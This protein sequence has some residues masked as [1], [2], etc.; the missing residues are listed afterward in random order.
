MRW[1]ALITATLCTS[2]AAAS[3]AAASDHPWAGFRDPCR[4]LDTNV[5]FG[6]EVNSY[7]CRGSHTCRVIAI[8]VYEQGG[9]FMPIYGCKRLVRATRTRR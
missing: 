5:G 8:G 2:I 6:V 3:P 1:L 9:G 4:I 7:R